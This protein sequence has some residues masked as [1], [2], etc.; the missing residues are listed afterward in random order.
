MTSTFEP[1]TG[2]LRITLTG[3]LI[4]G[5]EAMKFAVDLRDQLSEH[6]ML[7]QEGGSDGKVEVDAAGVGFV[8][9]SGLGMLIAARQSAMEHGA[10]FRLNA[11]GEQLRHLLNV[12]KLTEIF[13]VA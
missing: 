5:A 3:D 9:S 2:I 13:G 12:T 6:P 4:G 11:A 8:N 10:E 1:Q 7:K